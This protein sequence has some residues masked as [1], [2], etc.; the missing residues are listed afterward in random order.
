MSAKE[1]KLKKMLSREDSAL[2]G[3][4]KIEIEDMIEFLKAE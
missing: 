2:T 1:A 3:S 4:K